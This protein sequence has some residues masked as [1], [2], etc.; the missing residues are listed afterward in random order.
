MKYTATLSVEINVTDFDYRDVPLPSA[1]DI[2]AHWRSYNGGEILT[3]TELAEDGLDFRVTMEVVATEP[4][5]LPSV[6]ELAW[7]EGAHPNQWFATAGPETYQVSDGVKS[8][9]GSWEASVREAGS[10]R[11]KSLGP[12]RTPEDAK[13]LAQQQYQTRAV[14]RRLLQETG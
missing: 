11:W 13:A 8:L 6:T 5:S 12:A 10:E 7:D 4:T 1:K 14:M 9:F 2:L 3:G